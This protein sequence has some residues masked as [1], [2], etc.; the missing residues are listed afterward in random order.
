[1]GGFIVEGDGH[2]GTRLVKKMPN[3]DFLIS[4]EAPGKIFQRMFLTRLPKLDS[5]SNAAP[6]HPYGNGK[7]ADSD[8]DQRPKLR[9]YLT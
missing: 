2:I 3:A 8:Q 5:S 9:C 1:M 7:R 6:E 4:F